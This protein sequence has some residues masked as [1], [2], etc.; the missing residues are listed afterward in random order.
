[1]LAAWRD[2]AATVPEEVTSV[3]RLL[4]LPPLPDIPEPFRGKSF[5]AVEVIIQ[6]PEG[7]ARDL[8][9]PLRALRPEIDTVATIPAAG[10]THIHMDPEQPVPGISDHTML[11]ELP[12]AAIEALVL[13]AGKDSGS[14]LLLVD[15][16]QLG[17]ALG[18]AP[19]GAGA[20]SHLDGAF[21]MFGVGMAINEQIATAVDT[22]LAL[23]T[24]ALAPWDTG[25]RYLNFVDRP[26]D[27]ARFFEARTYQRLRD[28][29]A[30][31]DPS[32]LFFA[33]HPIAPSS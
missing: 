14:P 17:G 24:D 13:A 8:L 7:Q 1:M 33:N 6:Q 22:H 12:D 31:Y 18:R 27:P 30:T 9:A 5:A 2:W 29:K 21:A 15:I 11:R 28:I 16:R 4:Q 25:N 19:A 23:V 10:L 32:D 3:G 26:D 20:L